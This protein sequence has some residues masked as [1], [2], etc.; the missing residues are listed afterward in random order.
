MSDNTFLWQGQPVAFTAGESIAAALTA[1]GIMNFGPDMAG[2][3]TRYFCGI[4]A[5]QGCLVQVDGRLTES[6]LTP[7]SAGLQVANA[8]GTHG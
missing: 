6:C 8:G 3:D 4:G 2:R 1:A 5:C 7:A